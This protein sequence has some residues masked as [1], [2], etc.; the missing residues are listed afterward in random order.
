MEGGSN[1]TDAGEILIRFDELAATLQTQIKRP[2]PESAGDRDRL[3]K[4]LK[5]HRLIR[6]G[7]AFSMG[8]EDA[9]IAIRQTVLGIISEDA[10]A[11]A[12]EAGG[13]DT[14]QVEAVSEE[15]AE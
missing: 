4:E 13:I 10:I 7:A 11:A 1:L 3:L 2:L 14:E 9:L 15:V 12:L 5:R 8:D 6:F